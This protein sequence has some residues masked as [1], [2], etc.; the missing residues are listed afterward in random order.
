M[1]WIELVFAAV[2]ILALFII[3]L[4][5]KLR[6]G[7][8]NT[9]LGI[10]GLL[11]IVAVLLTHADH[12]VIEEELIEIGGIVFF[13]LGAMVSVETLTEIGAIQ[14]WLQKIRIASIIP[15]LI[16]TFF[17]SAILDNVTTTIIISSVLLLALQKNL[18]TAK[19]KAFL[20]M[21]L[22]LAANAGGV[23][24]PVGDVTTTMIWLA[25]KFS[26][27][28]L[29]L[30]T[31]IP[32]IIT[33]I[34]FILLNKSVISSLNRKL[35]IPHRDRNSYNK[36]LIY[37]STFIFLTG[38]GAAIALHH[39]I[40]PA[41]ILL[42]TA[43]ILMWISEWNQKRHLTELIKNLEHDALLYIT[44]VLLLAGSLKVIGLLDHLSNL[45]TLFPAWLFNYFIGMASAFIDNIPLTAILL[46][47]NVF[48]QSTQW[49][50]AVWALGVGGS[51]LAIGSA[52]G[53]IAL[54]K[55][56]PSLEATLK[57]ILSIFISYTTGFLTLLL[58]LYLL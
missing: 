54:S 6:I 31:L 53:I 4:E 50:E 37:L 18:L 35:H 49:L 51:L 58:L 16:A 8:H 5:D 30:Y 57:F 33:L 3:I 11:F 13:I 46:K 38:I 55:F 15:L 17:L 44:G 24:S 29:I 28:E 52:A 9:A 40:H 45:A 39:H 14:Y 10:G 19:E 56:K 43:G 7:K 32:S 36:S 20:V 1:M 2:S 42:T 26:T 23:W 34:V 41:I 27:S 21:G 12:A 47:A 48:T 25:K 22:A